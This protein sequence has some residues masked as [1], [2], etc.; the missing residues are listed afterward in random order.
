MKIRTAFVVQISWTLSH[1]F[2]GGRRNIGMEERGRKKER[3][4]E[5]SILLIMS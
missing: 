3:E 4:Q 2:M 5:M 1:V